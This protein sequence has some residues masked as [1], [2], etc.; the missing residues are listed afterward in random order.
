[1]YDRD[2]TRSLDISAAVPWYF[3][4]PDGTQGSLNLT[5]TTHHSCGRSKFILLYFYTH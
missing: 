4:H 1:M 2:G 5:Y 3:E